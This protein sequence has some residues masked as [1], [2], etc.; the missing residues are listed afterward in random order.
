MAVVPMV[1]PCG[2]RSSSMKLSVFLLPFA[3]VDHYF[4]YLN[5][6]LPVAQ[7]PLLGET[8]VFCAFDG[9]GHENVHHAP[10]DFPISSTN[11]DSELLFG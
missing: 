10:L 7:A 9:D 2:L 6:P 3:K 1:F 8:V 4:A 5:P 11:S